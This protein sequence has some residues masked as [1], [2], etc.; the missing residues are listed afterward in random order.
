MG[1][2]RRQAQ[3]NEELEK[4][5]LSL[6][7]L[8]VE[9]DRERADNAATRQRLGHLETVQAA[10][11]ATTTN[12]PP[13]TIT[14]QPPPAPVATDWDSPTQGRSLDD[15]RR[16]AEETNAT[17]AGHGEELDAVRSHLATVDARI[18]ELTQA[19]NNQLQEISQEIEHLGGAA[20]GDG[21]QPG[22][23]IEIVEERFTELRQNQIRIANE[24]A[25]FA[26]ALHEE[27]ATLA[28]E[29]RRS[30]R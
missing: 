27:L 6:V 17:A 18:E 5:Q 8:R 12:S 13:N 16:L 7:A 15:V 22:A 9:L 2:F 28:D 30:G 20:T 23:T 1:W 24:Q 26:K 3:A 11:A 29:W 19:M 10:L 21:V 4:L 14:A 25:R